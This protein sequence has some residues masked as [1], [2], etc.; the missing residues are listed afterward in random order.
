LR[1]HGWIS[2][3]ILF[4]R[5]KEVIENLLFT[6][7]IFLQRASSLNGKGQLISFFQTNKAAGRQKIERP[8]TGM[9]IIA[10][11]IANSKNPAT[12]L[13]PSLLEMKS[14][15]KNKKSGVPGFLFSV[16]LSVNQLYHSFSG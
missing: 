13:I 4:L 14:V 1:P 12:F 5:A 15:S 11:K 9:S 3:E 16:F 7:A 8:G 10:S 6:Q 2:V